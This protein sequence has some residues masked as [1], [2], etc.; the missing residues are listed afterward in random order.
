MFNVVTHKCLSCNQL[1]AVHVIPSSSLIKAQ[2]QVSQLH[3]YAIDVSLFT[4]VMFGITFVI[5]GVLFCCLPIKYV[6]S[7]SKQPNT[8]KFLVYSTLA[9]KVTGNWTVN[10]TFSSLKV[11]LLVTELHPHLLLRYEEYIGQMML[12]ESKCHKLSVATY[13][14]ANPHRLNHAAMTQHSWFVHFILDFTCF[15]CPCFFAS[16]FHP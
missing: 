11:S 4:F 14:A 2:L 3:C 16:T 7:F 15:L 10:F 8:S 5:F 6:W 12:P 13:V 1:A 9:L